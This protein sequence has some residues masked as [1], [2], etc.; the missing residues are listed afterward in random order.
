[1]VRRANPALVVGVL[2][3]AAACSSA[4]KRPVAAAA[5]PSADW[6]SRI[7][8]ADARYAQGHYLAL[9]DA[10]RIYEAAMAVPG[11]RA[12]VA[13]RYVR[14]TLALELRKKELG[15]LS[16]VAPLDLDVLASACPSLPRYGPWL[17]LVS[18]L[19]N[20]IKGSP[21]IDQTGGRTLEA[22]VDWVNAR[23]TAIDRELNGS[24]QV[25]DLAAALRLAL[26]TVFYY[27]FQDKFDPK[28]YLSLHPDS[29]LTA[30]QADVTTLFNIEGLEAL[31]A[32]EPGFSEVHYY[33]GEAALHD[34][35]L[36]TAER[37]Y[38]AAC[39]K[40]PESL[41]VL[42][43][44][45]KVAYQMEETER[46]LEWN[47]RA[48]ALLP[49]YRDALLGKG[50]CLGS[51][52]RNEEA[53]AVLGRLLELGT[54]Y[55]GEGHFWTA[56]NLNELERLVEA[57]RE[58]ESAKVFLVG[59]SDVSALSG[60]I[61]YRQGRLGDAEQDLREA[62]TLEPTAGDAAYYLGRLYADR[63]D[64]L[65]S[66]IYFAGA[67]LSFEEK[68]KGLEKKIGEIEASEMAPERKVAMV[69]KKRLQIQSVQAIKATC[70][71]NGA[72]GYH[73]AGVYERAL[74]LARL[75]AAHPAFAEKAAEL[76]KMI[77]ER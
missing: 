53:L 35:K 49:T 33:L 42:I 15:I 2:I 64:W 3:L 22:Q 20:K 41:S 5:P 6:P 18:G 54:Y 32:L 17:E 40:I 73:N 12:G 72:A 37:H 46:C 69:V 8:E 71:Y 62:L 50:L 28:T 29:R 11:Q 56:W 51:L 9:R 16:A 74:D 13:E 55:L 43:S 68:E 38:L 77:R 58:I 26:R 59:V 10:V 67:A 48:L 7:A 52:G 39:E 14:A 30:F 57:R 61:A 4:G 47:E 76:I 25:D 60:I 27:K 21:G 34:G 31:L 65:N 75:A 1:M 63:K 44:L 23:V 19:P 70:Q 45:A 66:G 24:A 36:L